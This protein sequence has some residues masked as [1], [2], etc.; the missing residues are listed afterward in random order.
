MFETREK[1]LLKFIKL[2]LARSQI[3][4]NIFFLIQYRKYLNNA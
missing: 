4:R 3:F 2:K 1:Y